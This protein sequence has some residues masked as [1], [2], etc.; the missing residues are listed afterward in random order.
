[1]NCDHC[2]DLI[3]RKLEGSLSAE[4]E[5]ALAGHLADCSACRAEL[6]LE[7]RIAESLATAPGPA[8]GADFTRRVTAQAFE[9]DR[10]WSRAH[11]WGYFV[12]VAA[13]AVVVAVAMAFRADIAALLAPLVGGVGGTIGAAV[14][15]IGVALG[16]AF[17]PAAAHAPA[18]LALGIWGPLA[19]AAVIVFLASSRIYALRRR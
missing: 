1:M 14:R 18:A 12:P 4:E 7:Q 16:Q 9:Q 5:R 3:A 11:R 19:C 2:V 17:R 8:L 10:S 6:L 15:W 13:L